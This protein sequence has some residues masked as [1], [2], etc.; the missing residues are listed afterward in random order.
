[1]NEEKSCDTPE[2]CMVLRPGLPDGML[3]DAMTCTIGRMRGVVALVMAQVDGSTDGM[4]ENREMTNALW[5]VEGML[6][7]LEALADHGFKQEF[8]R[9][10]AGQ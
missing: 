7:Q 1:M 8:A 3:I 10:R 2:A 4:T 5:A 6:D 9:R